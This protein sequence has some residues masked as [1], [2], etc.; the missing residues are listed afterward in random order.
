MASFFVAEQRSVCRIAYVNAQPTSSSSDPNFTLSVDG[1]AAAS[2]TYDRTESVT[3]AVQSYM[4]TPVING[5]PAIGTVFQVTAQNAIIKDVQFSVEPLTNFSQK[6]LFHGVKLN[7]INDPSPLF[8][9]D[10]SQVIPTNLSDFV[11][12]QGKPRSSVLYF[13][14]LTT[15]Y[16]LHMTNNPRNPPT[17][18]TYSV[19][20]LIMSYSPLA[21][22]IDE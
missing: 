2:T 20:D 16:M 9:V 1:T 15:G 10:G 6:L 14:A 18:T 7:Y 17:V 8:F 19:D 4:V 3:N 11:D 21:S 5:G 12:S 13:P 22:A